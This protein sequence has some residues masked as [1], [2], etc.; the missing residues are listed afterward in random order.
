MEIKEVVLKALVPIKRRLEVMEETWYAVQFGNKEFLMPKQVVNVFTKKI[1]H[2][3]EFSFYFDGNK[4]LTNHKLHTPIETKEVNS[5]NFV[6]LQDNVELLKSD[7]FTLIAKENGLALYMINNDNI[8]TIYRDGNT[9]RVIDFVGRVTITFEKERPLNDETYNLAKRLSAYHKAKY[10]KVNGRMAFFNIRIL[11]YNDVKVYTTEDS[12]EHRIFVI[13]NAELVKV[14]NEM[15]IAVKGDK[16]YIVTDNFYTPISKD[17]TQIGAGTIEYNNK[18]EAYEY[19]IPDTVKV[20]HKEGQEYNIDE[21]TTVFTKRTIAEIP[22]IDSDVIVR[23]V[24]RKAEPVL[25]EISSKP[26]NKLNKHEEPI[27]LDY[28]MLEPERIEEENTYKI[29]DFINKPVEIDY[30]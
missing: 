12:N 9:Y 21:T 25:K 29:R 13:E 18:Y 24:I 1:Y 14:N 26:K 19:T 22:N 5:H 30:C 15:Y 7:N 8:S 20:I 11:D 27:K 23:K 16:T 17:I 6:V 10:I 2:E 28:E 3:S 4:V